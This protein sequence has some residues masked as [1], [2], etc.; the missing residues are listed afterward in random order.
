[1]IRA[2]RGAKARARVYRPVRR[3]GLLGRFA[4]LSVA[5]ILDTA[6]DAIEERRW[7][8]WL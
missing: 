3:R 6:L 2:L 8:M 1:V 4:R 5:G 7:R